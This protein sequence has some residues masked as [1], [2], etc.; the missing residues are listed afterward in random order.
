MSGD[1]A[2]AQRARAEQL[3]RQIQELKDESAGAPK[4]PDD[5]EDASRATSPREFI[6][7][8]MHELDRDE[9]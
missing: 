1:E 3:R 8:R 6:H 2:A 9:E 7:R 5:E 4:E